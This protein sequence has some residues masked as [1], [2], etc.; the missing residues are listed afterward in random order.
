V[1]EIGLT[2]EMLERERERREEGNPVFADEVSCPVCGDAAE[3]LYYVGGEAVCCDG[4]AGEE[5]VGRAD[6]DDL[7]EYVESMGPRDGIRGGRMGW[8][9]HVCLYASYDIMVHVMTGEPFEEG[10]LRGTLEEYV[11]GDVPRFVGWLVAGG[12]IVAKDAE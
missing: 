2:A 5:L 11:R 8:T 10:W 6:T 7:M 4:C 3:K 9:A 1:R 12:K